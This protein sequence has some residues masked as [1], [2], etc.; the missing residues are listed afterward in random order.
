MVSGTCGCHDLSNCSGFQVSG[1]HDFPAS[2]PASVKAPGASK[3]MLFGARGLGG[4][5]L[6]AALTGLGLGPWALGVE[7]LSCVHPNSGS[8]GKGVNEGFCRKALGDKAV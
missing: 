5:S 1:P 6:G 2:L 8:E 7:P 3:C 4:L